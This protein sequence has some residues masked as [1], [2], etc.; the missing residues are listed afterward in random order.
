MAISPQAFAN[1]T[2]ATRRALCAVMVFA[3][4]Q[5]EG[6]I[7]MNDGEEL[8]SWSVILNGHV[9]IKRPDGTIEHLHMGDSFGITPTMEKLYHKGVMRTKVDDCQF[10]CIAQVDYYGIL[11]QVMT[12]LLLEER[13][14]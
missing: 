12:T 2:L 3:V 10:V 4:V 9:E 5:K 8:D 13:Q 1:M 14:F 6:T 11:H 7:V